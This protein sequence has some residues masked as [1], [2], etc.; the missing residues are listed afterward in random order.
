M[1]FGPSELVTTTLRKR[2]KKIQ[3][4]VTNHNILLLQGEEHDMIEK[5]VSGRSLFEEVSFDQNDTFVRYFGDQ[6]VSLASNQVLTA[7]EYEAK[8]AAVAVTIT[9]RDQRMNSGELGLI[10]LV[11]ARMAVAESTLAN[12][13]NADLFSDGALA[14][15]I[16]G[17]KLIISKTPTT[18]TIGGLSR[19]AADAGFLQNYKFATA[20]D[21]AGGATSAANIKS[22]YNKVLNNTQQNMNGPKFAIAGKTHYGFINDAAM[23]VQF[24][25]DPKLAKLGYR[26]IEFAGIKVVL[27]ASVNFG[28]QTLIQDDL[29]YFIDPKSIRFQFYTG[30]YFEPLEKIQSINQDTEAQLVIMMGNA[31]ANRFKTNGVLFDS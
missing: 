25:T 4:N 14:N 16:G 6:V 23:A 15:Q 12:N 31:T 27:G 30:A 8:Q 7:L 26:N 18:G 17:L 20:T 2:T 9:G 28:G 19:A 5:N 1:A 3:D 21:W 13:I 22:L 10:K 24:L 29:T 11:K